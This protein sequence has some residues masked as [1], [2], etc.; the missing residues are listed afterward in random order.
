MSVAYAGN[1]RFVGAI[2][3]ETDLI[4]I[5]FMKHCRIERVEAPEG[6]ARFL[7][8][9]MSP[10]TNTRGYAHGGLLM[11]MLDLALGHAAQAAVAGATSFA[12]IDMQTAFLRPGAG[13][14]TAEGRVLRAGR[15]IVFCEGEVRDAEGAMLA[16]GS[17]VFKA[18]IPK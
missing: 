12:T 4:E 2:G 1:D 14:I 16:R 9:A 3:R 13:R 10:L 18:I 6:A 11:T 15:E 7:V 17:G 8:E 5:P